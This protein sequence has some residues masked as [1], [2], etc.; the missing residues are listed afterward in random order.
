MTQMAY[1]LLFSFRQ[2]GELRDV[3]P[4][5]VTLRTTF[6]QSVTGSKDLSTS[7]GS[8]FHLVYANAP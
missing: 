1:P 5:L 3:R 6:R 4:A 2:L 7:V 8:V